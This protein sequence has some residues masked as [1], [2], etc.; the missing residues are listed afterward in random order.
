MLT[1]LATAAAMGLSLYSTLAVPG[2]LAYLNLLALPDPLAGL[3]APHVW[4]ALL[5]LA[6]VEGGVARFRLADLIWN[7]LHTLARP[8]A[9]LLFVSAALPRA[10]ASV[11]WMAAACGA[12][13]ALAVHV[14]VLAVH[15][16]SRTAG[17]R[18]QR[19]GF[20]LIQ[21]AGG[22][23][24]STLAQLAPP[25]AAASAAA[26][27][28]APLP[29]LPRLWGAASLATRSLASALAR[30]GRTAS[31]EHGPESLPRWARRA[32]QDDL[33][34]PLVPLRSAPVTLGRIGTDWPYYR[35]RLIMPHG[36][37]PIFI[38]HR[39]FRPRLLRLPQAEGSA[40]QRALVE[41]VWIE[42]ATPYAI[43]LAPD[44]PPASAVLAALSGRS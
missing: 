24:L 44:S 11:Q 29:W 43:C 17:P 16:A 27:I 32:L 23:V 28:L 19:R 7:V 25:I 40:D 15:T 14:Y 30:A 18:P 26:L 6:L 35:G 4:S 2:L 22:A 5:T 42:A 38:H 21:L 1:L 20:T 12:L 37:Q 8:L 41:T 31:W 13:F 34:T 36:R 9:A 33:G 10:P 3:A 39:G